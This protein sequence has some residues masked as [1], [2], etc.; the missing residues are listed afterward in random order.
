MTENLKPGDLVRWKEGEIH[1]TNYLTRMQYQNRSP[2][3]I[4]V[5]MNHGKLGKLGKTKTFVY[6]LSD[7]V[8]H[9][10]SGWN[11]RRFEKVE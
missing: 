10:D 8:N 6:L 2:I 5:R 3:D 11:V 7:L 1:R 4:V 9:R